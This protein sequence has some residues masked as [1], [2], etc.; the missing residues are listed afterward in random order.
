MA[1]G[2]KNLYSQFNIQAIV[3]SPCD[4]RFEALLNQ[5]AILKRPWDSQES[6]KNVNQWGEVIFT[7]PT[8][9]VINSSLKIRVDPISRRGSEGFKI[10]MQGGVVVADYVAY[11]C[12][13]TDIR[14]NDELFIGTRAYKV[15][16]VDDLFGRANLHHFQIRLIRIDNL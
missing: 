14:P 7:Y 6:V 15:L 13:S 8:A 10:E 5:T 16:L 11:T 3:T 4:A 12:P 9:P 2:S 1:D